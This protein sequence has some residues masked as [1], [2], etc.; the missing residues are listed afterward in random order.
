ML[1]SCCFLLLKILNDGSGQFTISSVYL[2]FVTEKLFFMNLVFSENFNALSSW[3]GSYG[4]VCDHFK[5]SL[6]ILHDIVILNSFKRCMLL[7]ILKLFRRSDFTHNA[8]DTD[9]DKKQIS[10]LKP[11]LQHQKSAA[12]ILFK[13]ETLRTAFH[14]SPIMKLAN[15][16]MLPLVVVQ[17]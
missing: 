10:P 17:T 6:P 14:V 15:Q 12:E 13:S 4:S 11:N 1:V 7:S 9:S 8:P 16:R 2:S 3:F 5:S